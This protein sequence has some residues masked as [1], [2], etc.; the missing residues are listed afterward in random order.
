MSWSRVWV[1]QNRTVL[2]LRLL[3]HGLILRYFKQQNASINLLA[4]FA[5]LK[6]QSRMFKAI[7]SGL[8]LSWMMT[9]EQ[10]KL[11]QKFSIQCPESGISRCTMNAWMD[12]RWPGQ[13]GRRSRWW[14]Q[15]YIHLAIQPLHPTLSTPQ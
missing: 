8:V 7:S 5:E 9:P 1:T 11:Q 3:L 14:S 6:T 13:K 4:M 2:N 10:Q 15:D 12:E